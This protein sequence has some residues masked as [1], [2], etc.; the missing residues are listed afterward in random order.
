MQVEDR[1]KRKGMQRAVFTVVLSVIIMS[2]TA[3]AVPN[4]GYSHP[5]ILIQP[6]ALKALI[7]RKE[8]NLRIIDVREKLLYLSGHIPG[9]VQVW[10]P[11]IEDRMHALPGMMAPQKQ[12]EDLMG[13]LGIGNTSTIVIYSD[14]PDNGRLWWILAY[15]GFPVKQMRLLDG[16]IDAW[17]VKSYPLEIIP[18]RVERTIF[19]LP[20]ETKGV[21][22]M[23]CSLPDVKSAL[24][25][26]DRAILDAR[27]KSEFWGEETKRGA[28]RSGR[29]PGAIWVE[30]NTVLVEEGPYKNYWKPAEEIKKI[31][32]VKGVTPDKDIY[33]Y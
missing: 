5:E 19:R 13:D 8:T 14:G 3:Q 27:S 2:Q 25:K 7:D 1:D 20:K 15:Y 6:E 16:G 30:W 26:P 12:I 4:G 32:S 18:P 21:K 11:D 9:A 31:F 33:I 23:L 17:K 29:I 24:R 10:R 22:T 28:T